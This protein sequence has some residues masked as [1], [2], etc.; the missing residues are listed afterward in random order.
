MNCPGNPSAWERHKPVHKAVRQHWKRSEDGGVRQQQ[1]S[2]LAEEAPSYAA[3]S[4]NEYHELLAEG[5][6]H[7][8][9]E[10]WRRAARACRKAIALRPDEA[11]AYYNLGMALHNSGHEVEAAQRFLEAKE[12]YPVGSEYWA[13]A[14]AWACSMLTQ[15]KCAEVAKPEWWNDKELK[16]LS[17]RVVRA[18]PDDMQATGRCGLSCCA[19]DVLLGRRGLARRRSSGRRPPTSSGLR[20]SALLPRRKPTKPTWRTGAAATQGPCKFVQQIC[21]A[22]AAVL[23]VCEC[24]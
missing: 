19:G 11:E 14:T 9:Q 16:A 17:A 1:N 23:C 6:R 2:E 21:G 20:H 15:T 8:S 10:H 24:V 18:A 3:Q 13:Q 7:L 12:L 4:G 5:L 22:C